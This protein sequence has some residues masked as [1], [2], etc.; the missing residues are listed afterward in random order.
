M[1]SFSSYCLILFQLQCYSSCLCT[2][3]LESHLGGLLHFI[4]VQIVGSDINFAFNYR[5]NSASPVV[6]DNM[7]PISCI[8]FTVFPI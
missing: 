8:L 3:K 1:E 2:A 4:F 6:F 5:I 7:F